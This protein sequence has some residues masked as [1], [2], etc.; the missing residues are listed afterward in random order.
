MFNSHDS[1]ALGSVIA[2]VIIYSFLTYIPLYILT[3]SMYCN[4]IDQ[5]TFVTGHFAREVMTE[6]EHVSFMTKD[7]LNAILSYLCTE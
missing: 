5:E 2:I 3:Q 1:R 7:E 6:R 4:S